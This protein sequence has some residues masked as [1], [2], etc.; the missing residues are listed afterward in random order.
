MSPA[1]KNIYENDLSLEEKYF[2]LR[3]AYQANMATRDEFPDVGCRS[4]IVDAFLHTLWNAFSTQTLG[5]DLT[6]T[7][8]TAHED[9]V[10]EYPNHY[11]EKEMDLFNN[12]KGRSIGENSFGTYEATNNS[13]PALNNGELV[14][15]SN[16]DPVELLQKN[17]Q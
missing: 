13:R 17:G 10:F 14:Y 12:A 4:G 15:L 11:K 8:T 1:E 3:S 5:H 16:K 9:I 2:Y 7:L 6:N